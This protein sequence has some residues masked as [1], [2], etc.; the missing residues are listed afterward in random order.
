MIRKMCSL[1]TYINMVN[2]LYT[3]LYLAL[4]NNGI[5]ARIKYYGS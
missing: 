5:V 2:F 4:I 3:Q 1:R